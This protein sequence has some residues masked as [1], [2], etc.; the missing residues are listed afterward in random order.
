M[1]CGA[2]TWKRKA[3]SC[4]YGGG[5]AR[6]MCMSEKRPYTSIFLYYSGMCIISGAEGA[7]AHVG[8]ILLLVTITITIVTMSD[9]P[10]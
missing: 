6:G 9:P 8:I 4:V 5:E 1:Q 3:H 10:V 2:C 7:C